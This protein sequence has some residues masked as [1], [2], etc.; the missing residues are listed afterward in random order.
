MTRR[1]AVVGRPIAQSLSPVIHG[2]WIA[3][4]G[5]DAT[6]EALAPEDEAAF[7]VLMDRLSSEGFAG[8]NVT[9]P[10]KGAAYDWARTSGLPAGAEATAAASVNLLVFGARAESTDGL[11]MVNA[12]D[13]QAPAW[14]DAA[15]AAVLGAGGA[16]RAAVDALLGAGLRDIR[17]INRTLATAEA[18]AA[19]AGDG[20]SA[21]GLERT[22]DALDG[23]G[24]LIQAA[25]GA[26]P[27]DLSPLRRG[28]AVLDMTYR[29]LRTPLLVKAEAAGLRPVD[30]LA[31]LI[32]QARPS[33]EALFGAPVPDIDVR[34]VALAAL[35]EKP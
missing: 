4:A 19:A 25:T 17:V 35:E 26:E 14:R 5:L 13:D 33:F 32:G 16:A 22:R 29:P 8:V 2:A 3:A 7:L 12:L 23:A 34:A 21:W 27:P 18:L 15:S 20:V 11:G 9:A 28:A 31:M 24:V 10:Y 6:Y 1:A 30:G